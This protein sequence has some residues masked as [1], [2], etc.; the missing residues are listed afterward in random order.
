MLWPGALLDTGSLAGNFLSD[1]V[2]N[3]LDASHYVYHSKNKF[4]VCSGLDNTCYESNDLLDLFITYIDERNNNK[5]SIN[6]TAFISKNSPIDLII[7]RSTIKKYNFFNRGKC[8]F[9]FKSETVGC[10]GKCN[11]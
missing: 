6:I 4:S 8:F 10:G 7:G 3:E 9:H 1:R 2:V 5:K 11:A